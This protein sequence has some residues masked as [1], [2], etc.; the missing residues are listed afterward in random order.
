MSDGPTIEEK[1]GEVNGRLAALTDRIQGFASDVTSQAERGMQATAEVKENVDKLLSEQ[2]ELRSRLVELEQRA[3]RTANDAQA[4]DAR[5]PGQRFVDSD[6]VKAFCAA[7]TSKGRVRVG[8]QAVVSSISGGVGVVQPDRVAGIIPL[9]HRRMTIRDLLTP[10]RTNSNSIQFWQ[11]SGFTNNAAAAS[12]GT[13]KGESTITGALVTKSVSTIAHFIKASKQILDDAPMMQSHIDGQ[14]RYGLLYEEELQLL[15]GD[16]T[17]VNIDGLVP[18]A[19]AFNPAFHLPSQTRIDTLR[20]ALLQAELALFPS[21][22]IVLHPTDMAQ[23]ELTKD[24]TGEY[25]YSMPQDAQAPRMW[26]RPCVSTP[27]MT[28]GSF[29]AGA[30]QLGAQLFDREDANVEL[31]TE[32][33]DNFQRNLVTLRGE[34]RLALAIYREEAFVTGAFNDAS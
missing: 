12:E 4:A 26:G 11:E 22:G 29:L 18:N 8:M 19:V 23:I 24:S 31:S 28:S 20:I 6:E 17:G 13:L 30:F 2:G 1:I 16:G 33:S 25:I 7:R 32:D 3:A 10:G 9:P 14:L 15:L 5:T 21:T 27:A 34:E